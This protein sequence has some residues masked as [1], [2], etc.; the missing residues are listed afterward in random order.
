MILL[1]ACS[2]EIVDPGDAN[3]STA[4][5]E[6]VSSSDDNEEDSEGVG[7]SRYDDYDTIDH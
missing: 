4:V 3:A 5:Q 6:E 2:G 7:D 1:V